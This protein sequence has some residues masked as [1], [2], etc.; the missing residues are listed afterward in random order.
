VP[1]QN[2]SQIINDAQTIS[3]KILLWGIGK[4]DEKWTELTQDRVKWTAFG[5]D[6]LFFGFDYRRNVFAALTKIDFHEVEAIK[7]CIS[8]DKPEFISC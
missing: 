2:A 4:G 3:Q 6:V 8:A 7:A 5:S 1:P